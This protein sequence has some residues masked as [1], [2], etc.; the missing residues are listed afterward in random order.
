VWT[1]SQNINITQTLIDEGVSF[2]LGAT[3]L[4]VDLTNALEAKSELNATIAEIDKKDFGGL[5][6]TV[7]TPPV[8]SVVPE[9]G[10]AVTMLVV[11]LAPLFARRFGGE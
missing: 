4:Y 2:L 8:G 10:S 7:N 6:I 3:R 9:P 5:S 11:L 1:G